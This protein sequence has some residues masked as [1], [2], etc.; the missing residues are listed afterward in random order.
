MPITMI[1]AGLLALLYFRLSTQVIGTRRSAQVSLGTGGDELLERRIRA[2]GNFAEYTP[3]ILL[4]IGLLELNGA[5]IWGV[6]IVAV[7][8]MA[9]RLLHAFALSS[10]TRRMKCRV[11]GMGLTFGAL[12]LGGIGGIVS[13]FLN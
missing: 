13:A 1:T 8:L 5:P 7:M 4:L 12:L 11:W 2:H 9:G 10:L 6:A 3:F